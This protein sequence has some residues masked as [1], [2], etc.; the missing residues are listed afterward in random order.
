MSDLILFAGRK[1]KKKSP[2]LENFTVWADFGHTPPVW[3]QIP[4]KKV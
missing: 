4:F 3:H 1:K 2:V